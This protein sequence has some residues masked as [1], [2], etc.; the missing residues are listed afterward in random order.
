V[1]EATIHNRSVLDEW[2]EDLMSLD[3]PTR[4]QRDRRGSSFFSRGGRSLLEAEV[5]V[6]EEAAVGSIEEQEEGRMEIKGEIEQDQEEQ[7]RKGGEEQ[8]HQQW[9]GGGGRGKKVE[10]GQCCVAQY[11]KGDPAVFLTYLYS[12]PLTLENSVMADVDEA[13]IH[14]SSILDEWEEDLMSLDVPTRRQCDRRGS[15]FFSRGGRSLLEAP[16][17][18][19]VEVVE[20]AVEAQVV[21]EAVE[22]QVVEELGLK[23]EGLW[24]S[25]RLLAART[26]AVF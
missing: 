21:E 24:R 4:I 9:E 1:D 19:E 12:S 2:E 18:V 16:E 3:V 6:E 26:A 22:A 5:E 11:E 20:E 10:F 25:H 8:H 13:T 15:S 14:N 7:G 17:E 23:R